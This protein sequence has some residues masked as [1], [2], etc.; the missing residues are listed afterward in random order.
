M[1]KITSIHAKITAIFMGLWLMCIL[2]WSDGFGSQKLKTKIQSKQKYKEHF[3]NLD[4][5]PINSNVLY[6]PV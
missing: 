3:K 5:F 4:G 6:Q 1:T 2:P